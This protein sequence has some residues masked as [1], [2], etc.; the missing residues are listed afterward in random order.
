M[1]T[2]LLERYGPWAVVTGSARA[3]GIGYGYARR[4]AQQGFNLVLVDILEEA[5]ADRAVELRSAHPVEVKAV[6]ADL[7]ESDSLEALQ[8]DTQGLE[9]GLLVANHYVIPENSPK[10][11]ELDLAVH[12]RILA[13]NARAYTALVHHYGNR[14]VGRGR[15]GIIMTSSAASMSGAPYM[16]PYSANKAYQRNLAESLWS[17]VKDDGVDVLVVLPGAVKT[18]PGGVQDRFPKWLSMEV[19]DLVEQAL[20]AL[21]RKPCLIPGAGNVLMGVL[22]YRLLPRKIM[23]NLTRAIARRTS[24]R[25]GT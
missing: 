23:L 7:G 5:L 12:D 4:L 20:A 11:L 21:G 1:A 24:Q 6:V 2:P 17:E 18:Q 16:G 3:E 19:D 15:G 8:R 13:V 14:M 22:L 10:I 25:D 9:V